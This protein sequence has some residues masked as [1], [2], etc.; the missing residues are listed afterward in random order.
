MDPLTFEELK[1][2]ESLNNENEK[3]LLQLRRLEEEMR[4]AKEKRRQV[5]DPEEFHAHASEEY[6]AQI[7]ALQQD[8]PIIDLLQEWRRARYQCASFSEIIEEVQR[9]FIEMK[10]LHSKLVRLKVG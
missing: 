8:A 6:I 4:V 9:H 2:I 5:V 3:L 10:R 7:K 1:E